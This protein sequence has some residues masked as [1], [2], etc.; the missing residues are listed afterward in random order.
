MPDVPSNEVAAVA[1][2]E[3]R[4]LTDAVRNL[5]D[6]VLTAESLSGEELVAAAA[7]VEALNTGLDGRAP[8]DAPSGRRT[9]S[10]LH[11]TDFLVRS[12]L[13]GIM[14]PVSPPF[15]RTWRDGKIHC[16]GSFT[17][18][19][20][21]PPGYVHGGWIALAFDEVLGMTSIAAE[22]AGMTGKLTVR[23]RRPTPLFAPLLFEGR[24]DHLEGNRIVV[25]GTVSSKGKVTAEAEG[26]F[27]TIDPE[28]AARY[29]G[30]GNREH[31]DERA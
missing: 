20:E 31:L 16:E 25:H 13:I 14:N 5:A 29:F 7:A 3:R 2:E 27:I 4:R 30:A 26:L 19:H 28:K 24:V 1:S 12:P 23:Y 22:H 10:E 17:A 18:V 9:R 6:I 15:S 11:H 21:G 8:G